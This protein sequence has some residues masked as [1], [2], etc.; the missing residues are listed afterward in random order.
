MN[1]TAPSRPGRIAPVATILSTSPEAPEL[2]TPPAPGPA[3]VPEPGSARP[4]TRVGALLAGFS[5]GVLGAVAIKLLD[6][7]I[8]RT[9]P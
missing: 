9:L 2:I 8:L 7:W 5:G 3:A 4:V 1:T 6:L